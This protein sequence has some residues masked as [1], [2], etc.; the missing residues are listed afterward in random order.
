MRRGASSWLQER[1]KLRI[2]A[3]LALYKLNVGAPVLPAV[4]PVRITDAPSRSSG[5]AFC[6]VNSV[7]LTLVA[8]VRS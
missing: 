8:K 6:T 2:A 1:A 4:E 7:P 5:S 3:L